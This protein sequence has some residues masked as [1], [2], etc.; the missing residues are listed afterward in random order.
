MPSARSGVQRKG[1]P[2]SSTAF[3]GLGAFGGLQGFPGRVD[4]AGPGQ[5][6]GR[7][8]G[9]EQRGG[10]RGVPQAVLCELG[11]AGE[12]VL[13]EGSGVLGGADPGPELV[14]IG[15][16]GTGPGRPGMTLR[17][18][19]AAEI[20]RHPG[21]QR[22]RPAGRG[23]QVA[24]LVRRLPPGQQLERPV[25][26]GPAAQEQ[27]PGRDLQVVL[28]DPPDVRVQLLDGEVADVRLLG[29]REQRDRL[30][31]GVD[32]DVLEADRG[33]AGLLRVGRSRSRAGRNR[34]RCR[35]QRSGRRAGRPGTAPAAS[36]P[37]RARAW[38]CS[39]RP[40]RTSSRWSPTA[41][42]RPPRRARP[43]TCAHPARAATAS[44]R[45]RLATTR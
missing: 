29:Q 32:Q 37:N 3:A 33:T 5:V 13:P 11:C 41:S 42:R 24:G 19:R 1:P 16:V 23:V 8:R 44:A 6:H 7:R 4:P 43:G 2:S 27:R 10:A 38:R 25:P 22:Q 45:V 28:R 36:A 30:V 40:A 21:E 17:G 39:A 35:W 9:E 14:E 20:N 31:A 15:R 12:V 26:D 18:V 34:A